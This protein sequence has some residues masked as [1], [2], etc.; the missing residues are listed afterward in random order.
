MLNEMITKAGAD[1]LLDSLNKKNINKDDI[2]AAI[3]GDAMLAV[4][5]ASDFSQDDSLTAKLNGLQVLVAGSINDK[6]KFKSLTNALQTKKDTGNNNPVGKIPKPFVFSNDSVFVASIS[7]MAAQ[8]FLAS[9]GN[10]D[11]IE[12]LFEPYKDYPSAAIVDLKTIFGLA[13]PLM[14][15]RK[16]QEEGH[17]LSRSPGYV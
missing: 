4:I 1:N 2:L 17:P 8:K 6:E 5:K 11:E 12:K 16:S 7:Q 15:K 9:T 13:G 14:L 10:N 3:K